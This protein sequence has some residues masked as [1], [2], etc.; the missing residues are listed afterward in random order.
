M[1]M[2]F[3]KKQLIIALFILKFHENTPISRPLLYHGEIIILD[4]FA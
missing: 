2:Y 1:I 4:I 3:V